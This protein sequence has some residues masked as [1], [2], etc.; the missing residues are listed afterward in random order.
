MEVKSSL[1]LLQKK[2]AISNKL[3]THS[4]IKNLLCNVDGKIKD[5]FNVWP[6]KRGSNSNI[7]LYVSKEEGDKESSNKKENW[8]N[9]PQWSS[10]LPEINV[11]Q[12]SIHHGPIRDLAGSA[13]AKD[14][15]NLFIDNAYTDI[16]LQIVGYTRSKGDHTFTTTWVEIS[17]YLRLNILIGIQECPQLAMYMYWDSDK[18]FGVEGFKET[19]LK[20]RNQ[21]CFTRFCRPSL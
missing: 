18:F 11:Q 12:F 6:Q 1:V 3:I 21:Q 8:P 9:T 4:K 13:T 15:F 19:I 17:M 5:F 20:C 10:T 14:F 2:L 7:E 16:I